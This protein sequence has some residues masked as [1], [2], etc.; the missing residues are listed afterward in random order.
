[1]HVLLRRYDTVE[2]LRD[3]PEE[4]W[5]AWVRR[6][7][8]DI[9]VPVVLVSSY[10]YSGITVYQFTGNPNFFEDLFS[11]VS[12]QIVATKGAVCST[13]Q[14]L[15]DWQACPLGIPTSEP[16]QA[17]HRAVFSHRFTIPRP[18][19]TFLSGSF[20][21]CI[22]SG[23]RDTCTAAADKANTVWSFSDFWE[24]QPLLLCS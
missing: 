17:Q 18:A 24:R 8:W 3:I 13:C 14:A 23:G 11:A 5:Q 4:R 20:F 7:G 19:A 12:K 15:E 1:M 10:R 6:I 9:P 22:E 16:L 2:A 21:G